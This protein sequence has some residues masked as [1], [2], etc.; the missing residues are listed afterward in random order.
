METLAKDFKG[1]ADLALAAGAPGGPPRR[2]LLTMITQTYEDADPER[3]VAARDPRQRGARGPERPGP[4][5]QPGEQIELFIGRRTLDSAHGE[6]TREC[7][8]GLEIVVCPEFQ[9]LAFGFSG[10]DLG[11]C[12][13]NRVERTDVHREGALRAIDDLSIDCGQ[14]Q[15]GEQVDELLPFARR[16]RVVEVA[17]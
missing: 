7:G 15:H 2:P 3:V 16:L 6:P 17:E 4:S 10:Q 13:V 5:T 9:W 14:I 11:G 8:G 1:P 12:D